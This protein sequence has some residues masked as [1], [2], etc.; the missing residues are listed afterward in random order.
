MEFKVVSIF[1]LFDL[2]QFIPEALKTV[3]NKGYIKQEKI[4][5]FSRSKYVVC[6]ILSSPLC[7]LYMLFKLSS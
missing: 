5:V 7:I 4:I 3:E 1:F 2:H 6:A